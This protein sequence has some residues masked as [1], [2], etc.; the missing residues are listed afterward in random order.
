MPLPTPS[1]LRPS[2]LRRPLVALGVSL[3][4][5]QGC[6]ET[7]TLAPGAVSADDSCSRFRATIAEARR[8]DI[9]QQQQ[10]A[11]VG[12]IFG[13]VLGAAVAGE[14][15]RAQGALIGAAAFG[16]AGYSSVYYR[17]KQQL[18]SDN[19]AL[20]RS[21]NSDA[22]AESRLVTRTGQ[23]A[24][25]LRSCR[26]GQIAALS[27]DVRAGRVNRTQGRA[28][29]NNLR[30][31]V[32]ADNQIIS[33]AFNGIGQ[34]VEAYVDVTN[35]VARADRSLSASSAPSV[36]NV[37]ASTRNRVNSDA[38]ARARID[39]DIEALSVLLG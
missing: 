8:S 33:A 9:Q 38:A 22:A 31:R 6:T 32:R 18:A 30:A 21:V 16:L 4:L 11:A 5:L 37:S 28:Q 34:R 12:A 20:L 25:S 23:A 35:A 29:L 24:A 10:A 7:I 13:A 39:R 15:N 19:R 17:Q 36:A 3:L 27:R 26:S 2:S 14:N 1:A